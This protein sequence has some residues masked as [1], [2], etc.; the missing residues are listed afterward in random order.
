MSVSAVVAYF[1]ILGAMVALAATIM[2]TLRV[3][4][5]I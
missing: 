2:F 4:K 5:L 1:G 3:V